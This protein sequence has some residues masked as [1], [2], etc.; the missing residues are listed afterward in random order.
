MGKL[1]LEIPDDVVE[2]IK[3]PPEEKNRELLK[4]LA[5]S[6]YQRGVLN[7]GKA[8][9]LAGMD[10]WTFDILLGKR[11]IKRHYTEENLN[12]DIKYA[13]SNL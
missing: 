2:A 8:R 3:L 10:K 11:H 9:A 12:E 6:L 1:K 5:V 13:K 7:F 4:E